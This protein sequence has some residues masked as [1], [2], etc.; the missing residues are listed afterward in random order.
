[1][2]RIGVEL[3]RRRLRGVRIDG[4]LRA[5]VRTAEVA[6]DGEDIEGAVSRLHSEL[7]SASRIA[8]AVDLPLLFVK[9]LDLPAVPAEEKTRI[10]ALEPER[11]FPI[12]GEDVVLAARDEDALVFAARERELAPALDALGRLGAPDRVEPSPQAFVRALSRLGAPRGEAVLDRGDEGAVLVRFAQG[13]VTDARRTPFGVAGLGLGAPDGADRAARFV[14]GPAA[15]AAK[16][17]GARPLPSRGPVTAAFLPA[18]G[19]ALGIGAPLRDV[20]V[21]PDLRRR[22]AGRRRR[23]LVTASVLAAAALV[24]LIRS[25]DAGATRAAAALARRAE[26]LETA[27]AAALSMESERAEILRR[28]DAAERLAARR[29]DP[30]AAFA[31]LTRRLPA[32]AFI[33]TIRATGGEWQVEG[34]AREAAPL[35][36]LLESAPEL[37]QVRFLSATTRERVGDESHESFSIAFRLAG[38]P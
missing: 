27:A 8:V 24:F 4:G 19:A 34:Y 3:G 31:A 11:Y 7:G 12:R 38:A 26:S 5:R 1:M 21:P 13:V 6:W 23:A 18:W 25:L 35:V 2:A 28:R 37:E 29:P 22:I 36:P 32:G 16:L 15:M 9:P 30:L 14:D 20:L 17:A 10:V 33:R